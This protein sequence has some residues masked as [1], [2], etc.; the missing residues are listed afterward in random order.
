[1]LVQLKENIDAAEIRLSDEVLTE[2]QS[3][4]NQYPDPAP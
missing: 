3:V 4:H 1:N 2:I